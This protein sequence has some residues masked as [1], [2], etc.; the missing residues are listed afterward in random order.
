M[1]SALSANILVLFTGGTI[2]S[3]RGAHGIDV[4]AGGSYF[5]MEQYA[6]ISGTPDV[7]FETAQPC[8][9]LSENLLPADW[10]LLAGA[11]RDAW[12]RRSCDGV[13]VTHGSDTL[14]F[15]AAMLA[16]LCCDAPIPV[17]LTAANY[18]LDDPRSNGLANFAAAVSFIANAGLPGVFALFG[19]GRGESAVYLG[20]RITQALPFTDQFG[21]PYD[22]PFGYMRGDAFEPVAHA[23]NPAAAQLASRAASAPPPAPDR[24]DGW[25][26]VLYIKPYPGLDYSVYDLAARPPRAVLHDTYHSGTANARHG[27][28]ARALPPFISRCRELGV[29]FYLV[30]MRNPAGDMYASSA[31]LVAAGGIPLEGISVEAALM[32]LLLGCACFADPGELDT[33]MRTPLFY[34]FMG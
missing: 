12:S 4:A 9:L 15:S 11:I 16:Y 29:P 24:D 5:L 34:E 30:P 14:S 21:A 17:V 31:E 20:T 28:T 1:F 18:P 23:V 10:T 32:K 8:N 2:G 27:A 22:T 19:D 26:P 6:Q 3:R 13:I 7:S 33:F 25:P